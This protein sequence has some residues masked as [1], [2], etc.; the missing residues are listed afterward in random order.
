MD[1]LLRPVVTKRYDSLSDLIEQAKAAEL[2][3][4]RRNGGG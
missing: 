3:A 4:R 2:E 1:V